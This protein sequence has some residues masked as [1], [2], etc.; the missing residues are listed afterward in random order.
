MKIADMAL[1]SVEECEEHEEKNH[2]AEL[3]RLA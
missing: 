1:D 3:V 2:S